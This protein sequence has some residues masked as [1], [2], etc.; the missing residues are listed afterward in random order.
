M[1]G[2]GGSAPHIPAHSCATEPSVLLDREATGARPWTARLVGDTVFS[3]WGPSAFSGKK[4][5]LYRS[6]LTDGSS[7]MLLESSSRIEI[8]HA[9]EER[10]FLGVSQIFGEHE[11]RL[12]RI[13]VYRHDA[14]LERSVNIPEALSNRSVQVVAD[15]VLIGGKGEILEEK[16]GLFSLLL[17]SETSKFLTPSI[18]SEENAWVTNGQRRACRLAP[19]GAALTDCFELP[20]SVEYYA[21]YGIHAV[22]KTGDTVFVWA[23]GGQG[24]HFL[25]IQGGGPAEQILASEYAFSL[26][27]FALLGADRYWFEQKDVGMLD[28]KTT[29]RRSDVSAS[30]ELDGK[31][32]LGGLRV[33][34][35]AAARE[36]VAVVHNRGIVRFPLP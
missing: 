34:E 21:L 36:G 26:N 8:L 1:G 27:A 23:I 15:R 4:S 5:A 13:D 20:E 33:C 31:A 25:R 2:S 22:E 7:S 6:S 9:T 19:E 28:F 10:L 32:W 16:E 17:T 18:P 12:V 29:V 3:E 35:D 11:Q 30:V 14:A 24:D